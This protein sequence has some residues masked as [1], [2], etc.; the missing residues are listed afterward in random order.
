MKRKS[1]K[2]V[3]QDEELKL[4]ENVDDIINV[5]KDDKNNV[6]V[7]SQVA[8]MNE[9][10]IDKRIDKRLPNSRLSESIMNR[11]EYDMTENKK[12][13]SMLTS[14]KKD[15]ELMRRWVVKIYNIYIT[16]QET[17]LDPFLQFRNKRR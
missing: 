4:K 7:Y 9:I 5:N 17:M 11:I 2:V 14:N 6:E 16:P 3:S 10:E 15:M 12:K 13:A 8:N 1:S